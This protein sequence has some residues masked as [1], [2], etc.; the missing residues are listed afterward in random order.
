MTGRRILS[1]LAVMGSAALLPATA[2]AQA[3]GEIGG[4]PT[5][6]HL[7]FPPPQKKTFFPKARSEAIVIGVGFTAFGKVE[8]VGQDTKAGLCIFVDHLKR[9]S[10]G[11]TCGPTLLP[12]VIRTESIIWESQRRRSHSRTE[13]SGFMQPSVARVIAVAHLRKGKKRSRNAVPG[14]VAAPGSEILA[15]LHQ[16]TAFGYFVAD[17]RGCITDVKVRVHAFDLTGLRLGSSLANLG[18]PNRFREFNPCEPG[19]SSFAFVAAAA[20]RTAVAP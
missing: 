9:G 19:S 10:S 13:F 3:T 15:R 18:F 11:G 2:G 14:V 1:V 5:M 7:P 12:K 20:A 17:F 8:I 4:P 6:S 16:P